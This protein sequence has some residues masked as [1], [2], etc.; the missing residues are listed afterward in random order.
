VAVA[1]TPLQK[2]LLVLEAEDLVD[3]IRRWKIILVRRN[4]E[5]K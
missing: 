4:L 3:D 5:T 1:S 2:L